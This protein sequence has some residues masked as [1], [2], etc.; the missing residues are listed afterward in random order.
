MVKLYYQPEGFWFGDCMPFGKGGKYYLFH[1]RDSR[2]KG[3]LRNPFSWDLS[4]TGDF[5]NYEDKGT[6]VPRGKDTDQDQYIFAGSVFED[7]DGLFHAFYTG[8]NEN[9]SAQGKASQVL[10]HATSKDLLKWEKSNNKLTLVPQEG[11]DKNDWRD[12]YVLWDDENKQYLLILG[13]RKIQERKILNG[14]NVHFVSKDLQDWKFKGPFYAPNIYS[15]HEMPDLFRMGQWWYLVISEYSDRNKIVYRMSKSINGPWITP[16]DDA[17]D[18]RAYYAGRTFCLDN[19]RILFGWVP[20]KENDNDLG[21]FQWGGTFMPH[22]ILQRPDGTLGVKIPDTVWDAF[23]GEEKYPDFEMNAAGFCKETI[24]EKA[25]GD[26]FRLEANI[27]ILENTHSFAVKIYE[28]GE[29][30]QGCQFKF[31]C[32][33]N[34]VIFEASPNQPWYQNMNIGLERPFLFKTGESCRLRVIVDDTIATLYINDVA[35]NT[36]IYKRPGECV[37][38]SVIDG[39]LG[40]SNVT[41]AKKLRGQHT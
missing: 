40:V 11:Y 16:P 5:V 26:I 38:F 9:Y 33:E 23:E 19:Q 25:S 22:E 30:R 3:P 4:V 7:I 13:A 17:F 28:N 15:M 21:N 10:M 2:K 29:T 35:L 32:C 12:P 6:A 41:L 14:C 37:G 39:K 8:Y 34:R 20:T 1:Q 27:V 36:R 24:I 31:L 18:G